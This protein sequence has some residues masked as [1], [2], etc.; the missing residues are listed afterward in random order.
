VHAGPDLTSRIIGRD[1]FGADMTTALPQMLKFKFVNDAIL[2]RGFAPH[3]TPM[4]VPTRANRRLTSGLALLREVVDGIIAERRTRPASE[5]TQDMLGLLL[6]FRDAENS[7]DRMSDAEVADQVL[8]FLLAGHDTTASTLAC[9]LV[10]LARAPK[11]QQTVRDELKRVL[12]GRPATAD[13]MA[14]LPWTVRAVREAMRLYPAA[15]SI[16]RSNANDEVLNGHRIPAGSAIV[17]SPWTVHR[18]PKIWDNPET[19]D[20]R[21][22]DLPTGQFPGDH[23]LDC[24][25]ALVD[26]LVDE[27]L[28]RRESEASIVRAGDDHVADT[29]PVGGYLARRSELVADLADQVQDHACQG[30]G[31]PA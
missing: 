26:L 16:G 30:G 18:S 2:Q 8:I 29:C 12:A 21:R 22:F 23:K 15:H 27:V 13:D 9:L 3:P 14:G 20:P 17:V 7:Q 4:W 6:N 25:V 5:Q 1:L 19:F 28:D 31:P 24:A 11:W 10:E